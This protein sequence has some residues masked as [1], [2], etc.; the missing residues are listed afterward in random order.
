MGP[1]WDP[2]GPLWDPSGTP[3]GC[4]KILW[5]PI[6]TPLDP[7]G[8]LW[9]PCGTPLGPLGITFGPFPNSGFGDPQKSNRF[10]FL[11]KP[12][13]E[14]FLDFVGGS[15]SGWQ[16]LLNHYT[17]GCCSKGHDIQSPPPW[18][19]YMQSPPPGG[20][21][22][23]PSPPWMWYIQSPHSLDAS[24]KPMVSIYIRPISKSKP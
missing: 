11:G 18:M 13:I 22:S 21:T 4:L 14:V 17:Q 2:F 23:S 10:S 19:W 8:P 1:L 12:R 9:D 15:T 5:D 3:V 20:T 6:G 24:I 7:L 16:P